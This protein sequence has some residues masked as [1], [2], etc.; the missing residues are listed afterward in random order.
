[1]RGSLHTDSSFSRSDPKRLVIQV[2]KKGRRASL[3]FCIVAS[4]QAS[5]KDAMFDGSKYF[6]LHTG[7]V[8]MLMVM[9]FVDLTYHLSTSSV[10]IRSSSAASM[11][12]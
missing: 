11:S 1:M 5:R 12:Q 10:G 8:R 6:A 4:V 3:Q 9:N 7:V 2:A